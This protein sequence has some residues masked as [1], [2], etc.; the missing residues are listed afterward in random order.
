ME[1]V[2]CKNCGSVNYYRTEKSGQHLKAI[3]NGCDRYIKF[4]PQNNP[5][6]VMPFGKFKDREIASLTSKEEVEYL[7]WG[8]NNLKLSTSIKTSITNHLNSL[9]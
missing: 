1:Q 5:V 9:K 3:C 6:L 2:T 4:L 8:V 7:N